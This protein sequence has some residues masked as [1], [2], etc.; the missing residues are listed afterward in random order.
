[1]FRYQEK[2]ADTLVSAVELMFEECIIANMPAEANIPTSTFRRERLY[3]EDVDDTFRGIYDE[4][5]KFNSDGYR[6]LA[7]GLQF[8]CL[9]SMYEC[10]K[11]PVGG[12]TIMTRKVMQMDQW[13]YFVG[14]LG[15][16]DD[17]TSGFT[18][19]HA[20]L[21][22]VWA[23]MRVVDDFGS[24]EK[25]ESMQ[26]LDFLEAL[27][28]MAELVPLPPINAVKK[29]GYR[30]YMHYKKSFD[31]GETTITF[32]K[33]KSQDLMAKKSRPLHVKLED[34]LDHCFRVCFVHAGFKD[35]DYTQEKALDAMK[36]ILKQRKAG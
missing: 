35:E 8:K 12:G 15:F 29:E 4:A 10:W 11:M 17:E 32:P 34:L 19:R 24:L 25:F 33:R 28:R 1:M 23:Q 26:F 30:S 6:T 3:I 16:L 14:L 13:M 22:Y 5:T 20:R 9:Q 36:L 7:K 18:I 31:S 2:I 21:C 27:A